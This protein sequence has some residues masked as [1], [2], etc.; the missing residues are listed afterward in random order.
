MPVFLRTYKIC[1]VALLACFASSTVCAQKGPKE[2]L[3]FAG[4]G[5]RMPLNEIGQRIKDLHGITVL[6]DYGGSGRLGNKILAG[7]IPDLFI[8]GSDKWA[9]ILKTEGY[10]E[11]CV[12]LAWHGSVIITPKENN[13]VN[14][15]GDFTDRSNRLVLGDIRACAI[16]GASAEI[17][18]KAG[19][20]ESRMNI[21]ARAVTVK[22][23]ILWIEGN[24]AEAAVV[25]RA[26]AVQSGRVRIIGIPEPYNIKNIIPVCRMV[27]HGKE[28][29]IYVHYLL[30]VEG[31]EIFKKYGFEVME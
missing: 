28:A 11:Y 19:L 5:M 15:L 27:R 30:S 26:D 3:V 13:R 17:F 8:P 12:P 4:A 21:R 18:K 24:N 29:E 31:K 20:E 9:K 2:L 10:V 25:W 6:Y 23:L 1:L 16:G 7:Q 14:S 22:Q